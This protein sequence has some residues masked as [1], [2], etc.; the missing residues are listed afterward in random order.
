MSNVT[1]CGKSEKLPRMSS[2]GRMDMPN[3][4][5][6]GSMSVAAYNQNTVRAH[7]SCRRAFAATATGSVRLPSPAT[8]LTSPSW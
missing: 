7:G 5:S 3:I 4:H 6:R 2:F 8:V 1:R